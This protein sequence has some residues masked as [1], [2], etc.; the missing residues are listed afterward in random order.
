LAFDD[1]YE[2]YEYDSQNRIVKINDYY[3]GTIDESYTFQY[4]GSQIIAKIFEEGQ[5]EQTTT[6]NLVDNLPKTSTVTESET[7]QVV[8]NTYTQTE[9]TNSS[10]EYNSAGLV[11]KIINSTQLTSTQPGFTPRT[12]RDTASLT[13]LNGNL[14]KEV[15]P[16]SYGRGT[17]TYEYYTDKLNSLPQQDAEYIVFMKPSKNL[18][19]KATGVYTYSGGTSTSTTNYTYQFNSDG[20]IT[21]ITEVYQSGGSSQTYTDVTIPTYSCK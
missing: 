12:E 16:G 5:L 20:L 7:V 1:S 13:Y 15:Y 8:N 17:I 18:I 4:S 19:K 21:K 2:T 3:N 10:Y 6:Y 11:T 9:V 14:I